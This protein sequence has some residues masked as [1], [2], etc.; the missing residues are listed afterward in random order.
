MIDIGA[1]T[2]ESVPVS[3][4]VDEQVLHICHPAFASVKSSITLIL[5]HILLLLLTVLS[6]CTYLQFADEIRRERKAAIDTGLI[7][8]QGGDTLRIGFKTDAEA[9]VSL[10][11]LY[12][13]II[14]FSL[15]LFQLGKRKSNTLG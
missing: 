10:S 7:A 8:L 4:Y 15:F 5:K 2:D 11:I 3:D 9:N 12:T 13:E 6:A 14:R 1:V